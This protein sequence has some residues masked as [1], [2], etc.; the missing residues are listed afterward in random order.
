[1]YLHTSDGLRIPCEFLVE[2]GRPIEHV[3]QQDQDG[4]NAKRTAECWACEHAGSS[5][6]THE[7]P[8]L[9]SPGMVM[10]GSKARDRISWG[11]EEA[12]SKYESGNND[13]TISRMD[14]GTYAHISDGS[15][16]PLRDVAIEI[17]LSF[18]QGRHVRD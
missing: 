9:S 1:M 10:H 8:S 4:V 18:K 17:A 2:R 12:R 16:V 15:R 5:L 7:Q 14:D 6:L 11:Y 3:L 13:N